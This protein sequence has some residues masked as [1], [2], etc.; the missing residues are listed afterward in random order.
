MLI[1]PIWFH[2]VT[3]FKGVFSL[4]NVIIEKKFGILMFKKMLHSMKK[5]TQ[6]KYMHI[7]IFLKELLQKY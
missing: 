7:K 6:E 2:N 5:R 3:Y 4:F 1:R